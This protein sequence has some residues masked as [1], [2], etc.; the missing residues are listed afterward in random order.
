MGQ[1]LLVQHLLMRQ[2]VA[3]KIVQPGRAGHGD[4][5]TR[6]FREAEAAARLKTEHVTRVFDV[7][8]LEDG[9]PYMVMELLEGKDLSVV[10]RERSPAPL[11]ISDAVDYILQACEAIGEAHANGIIHRDIK[12]A[13]L[14]LC[15]STD[16]PCVKVIDF[17]ISKVMDAG[18]A[19]TNDG[20]V[21]SPLYMSVEQMNSSKGVDGRADIWSLGVTLYELIAGSG[22]VPFVAESIPKLFSVIGLEP[23]IPLSTYRQDVP[24]GLWTIVYQ[25]LEKDRDRRFPN[26]ARLAA[27]L[28]PYASARGA[29]YV[30]RVARVLGEHVQPARP[31]ATAWPVP[32]LP[33]VG[34]APVSSAA[35]SGTLPS[36]QASTTGSGL[37]RPA[38]RPA[39]AR[40]RALA[41]GLLAGAVVLAAAVFA[42][43][44]WRTMS[45]PGTSAPAAAGSSTVAPPATSPSAAPT[46]TGE[47]PLGPPPTV[48]APPRVAPTLPPP[49]VTPAPTPLEAPAAVLP[50]APTS[51]SPATS[52]ASG[53]VPPH[54]QPAHHAAP[55]PVAPLQPPPSP[56]PTPNA[57]GDRK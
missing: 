16:A 33:V 41:V 19:L 52:P 57:Y 12:P 50:G 32:Q 28:A 43:V 49:L 47:R 2:H 3:M 26:V 44:R 40:R 35:V 45:A 8:Y 13:N 18:L 23:P 42:L 27:A 31:T 48:P 9:A 6:F 55:V 15:G 5:L 56:A 36:A 53:K 34:A 22:N 21:G 14:F 4:Y 24:V 7:G 11:P 1:V 51:T 29:L 10:L 54:G 39:A 20:M 38:P 37:I 17:G 25:C 46:T 30:E